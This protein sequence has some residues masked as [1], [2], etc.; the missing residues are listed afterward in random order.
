MTPYDLEISLNIMSKN[1]SDGLQIIEQ[2]IPFFNPNYIISINENDIVGKR[3]IPIILTDISF[4]DTFEG[5]V[6][7]GFRILTWNLNFIVQMNYYKPY[8]ETD[9]IKKIYTDYHNEA[10]TD[11]IDERT[12]NEPIGDMVDGWS[13]EQSRYSI[14]DSAGN[15]IPDIETDIGLRQYLSDTMMFIDVC[16]IEVV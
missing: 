4:E 6:D 5:A 15:E 12:Y 10:D 13:P 1:M 14:W 3:N 7:D 9:P 11:I 2:I 16:I 8:R